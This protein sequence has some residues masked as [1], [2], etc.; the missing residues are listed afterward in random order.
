[1]HD[2]LI[3]RYIACWNEGD[4]ARRQA[5]IAATFTEGAQYCDPMLQGEG[6][7]GIDALIAAAQA[8]FPGLRFRR[9][10]GAEAHHDRLRFAWELGPEGAAAIA[11]GTDMAVVAADGRLAAVTG[12]IDFAPQG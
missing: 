3:E 9:R 10:G 4:A 6:H 7:A 5:L 8:H 1:M 2:A 11:G 12:F